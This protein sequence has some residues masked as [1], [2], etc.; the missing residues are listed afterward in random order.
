[1][2]IYDFSVAKK[3]SFKQK[4]ISA[5]MCC[6]KEPI[7]MQILNYGAIYELPMIITAICSAHRSFVNEYY[8]KFSN[9]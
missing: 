8:R 9:G 1:M 2:Y 6:L 7:R 3:H 4:Q 5:P